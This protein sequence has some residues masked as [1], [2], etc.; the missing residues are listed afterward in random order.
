MEAIVI[1]AFI[2][3]LWI[4]IKVYLKTESEK[5]EREQR[6]KQREA[7][8]KK[9]SEKRERERTER[10]K[11]QDTLYSIALE[12]GKASGVN[13][14]HHITLGFRMRHTDLTQEEA[15]L[16]SAAQR[17][18][19]ELTPAPN[20]STPPPPIPEKTP[21]P[22]D[23]RAPWW[24]LYSGWYRNEKG[25]TCEECE[26]DLTH[27]R[28]YLQTHHRHGTQFNNPEDLKALCLGCHAEQL[29]PSGHH[30]LKEGSNYTE[31][32]T[33]Y[34]EYWTET[35]NKFKDLSLQFGRGLAEIA[36]GHGVAQRQ[37]GQ[38]NK[39]IQDYDTAIRLNP[40]EARAYHGRGYSKELL[41]QHKA[42]IQDFDT[43]IRLNP[44]YAIAY[45][46]R[47]SS[48]ARL[49]Q[50]NKAIQD[51]DTAIRLNFNDA[52]VYSNRGWSKAR[53]GQHHEAIKDYDTAIHLNPN[54]ERAH[55]HRVL[56]VKALKL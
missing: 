51:Y 49:G 12:I 19:K 38:H 14:L 6:R 23:Y 24:K 44:D 40:D 47:G 8:E 56:S 35:L 4:I 30:R 32:M 53:L 17:A 3:L 18:M 54:D 43:A 39:A 27:D 50:H 52:I 1:L 28:Y 29:T 41:E 5:Y 36:I 16:W 7:Q 21:K 22:F 48:K 13:H 25:W 55:N 10:Q 2:F 31:F 46:N 9:E 42:A 26:L 33:K 34:G 20:Y 37:F 45:N 11:W 15:D